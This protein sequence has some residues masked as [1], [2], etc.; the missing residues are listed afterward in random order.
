MHFYLMTL[1]SLIFLNILCSSA[2][3]SSSLKVSKM[4]I[5]SAILL[6]GLIVCR[7]FSNPKSLL[8]V[9]YFWLKNANRLLLNSFFARIMGIASSLLA[10]SDS[11]K[12]AIIYSIQY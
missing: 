6:L 8:I 7:I 11:N 9:R 10:L 1:Y 2:G 4:L 5:V 3:V 12:A